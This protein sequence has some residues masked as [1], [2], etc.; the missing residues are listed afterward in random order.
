MTRTRHQLEKLREGEE[1]V[2]DLGEEE[3]AEG[4]GEVPVHANNGKSHAGK[5]TE[6]VTNKGTGGVEVVV[7]ET[8]DDADKGEDEGEG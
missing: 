8:E 6:G 2:R 3:E 4:F 5:I 7:K 1:K